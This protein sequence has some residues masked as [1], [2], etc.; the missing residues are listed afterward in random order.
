MCVGGGEISRGGK[1]GGREG[2]RKKKKK[3]FTKNELVTKVFS[4]SF[5]SCQ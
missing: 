3:E 5:S 2:K 4:L 1:K